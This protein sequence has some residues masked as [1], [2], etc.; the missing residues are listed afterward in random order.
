M[1]DSEEQLVTKNQPVRVAL[2]TFGCKL[3]QAESELIARQ[4]AGIGYEIVP[5]DDEADVYILNTCTVTHTADSKARKW[6]RAARKHAPG[7]LLIACGCYAERA[8]GELTKATGTITA[9]NETKADLPRLVSQQLGR[10][11]G[12]NR[13]I[14]HP[15]T[16]GRRNRSLVKIQDGCQ[17][18][19]SYCI[20]PFVR[21]REISVAPEIL[22]GEIA[23]RVEE[24]CREVVLTGTRIGAYSSNGT[25]LAD[26]V[27][28][29]LAETAITRLRISSLQP[30]EIS[31]EL[32]DLW[33]NPRLC[34]HFH[35]ALQS[36]S[37]SVLKR[38]RRRYSTG[39]YQ[40]A[41]DLIRGIIPMTAITTDIIVGF[42]G[43]TETEFETSYR[44]ARQSGF[45]RIHVF[46][47]SPRQGTA[48]ADMENQIA[49]MTKNARRQK[50]LALASKSRSSFCQQF[51]GKIADVL[52]EQPDGGIWSGLTDNYI[53][54][55]T[56]SREDLSNQ[57]R[58]VKLM[59]IYGDGLWGE[60]SSPSA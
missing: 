52:W 5:P 23:R 41:L 30:Q 11:P 12:K 37:D 42:P 33:D 39:D 47:Y 50:M 22:L 46:P 18:F 27:R 58:P 59:E 13:E 43:E 49:G 60:V 1:F 10:Y 7:A 54:V 21:R 14:S 32:L 9:G 57:I 38:M 25:Y 48:A 16:N 15:A 34:R 29:I 31:E 19:C 2:A 55:Y 6:L 3:N 56:E 35:L 53:K 51:L 36:G 40:H 26:L 28:R 44:F 45:A 20:V 4:F 24:G 8:A 17:N